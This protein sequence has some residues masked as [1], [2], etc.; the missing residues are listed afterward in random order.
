M[1]GTTLN[2]GS[3]AG[4]SK[5]LSPAFFLGLSLLAH[6]TFFPQEWLLLGAG[7]AFLLSWQSWKSSR[8]NGLRV[9]EENGI[10]SITDVLLFTLVG[11]SLLGLWH[12]VKSSEGWMDAVR[13]GTLWMIYHQARKIPN[14]LEQEKMLSWIER[15]GVLLAVLAW[16]KLFNSWFQGQGFFSAGTERL[17]S[18]FGY[19]NALGVYLAA[20]LLLRPRSKITQALLLLTLLNTGSRAAVFCF[21][22]VWGVQV[23]IRRR[24]AGGAFSSLRKGVLGAVIIISCLCLTWVLNPG[25]FQRL[26]NWGIEN[27]LGERILYLLDG[28][29]LSWSNRGLPR[30]GGWFAFPLVQT[31]P[32]WTSDPH[33]IWI[34]VLLNQGIFGVSALLFWMILILKKIRGGYKHR[35]KDISLLSQ[36]DGDKRLEIFSALF[37]LGWHAMID[38][39]FLFGS[40]GI[41]FW[42]LW[43]MFLPKQLKKDFHLSKLKNILAGLCFLVLALILLRAWVYPQ[44]LDPQKSIEQEMVK[45]EGD[46]QQSLEILKKSLDQDQTQEKVRQE[47]ANLE[48]ELYGA[49][50]LKAAEQVLAWEKFDIHTYEWLQG[51]AIEEA[52]KCRGTDPKD[53]LILYRWSASLPSRLEAASLRPSE[54]MKLLKGTAEEGQLNLPDP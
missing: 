18:L 42:I 6:G 34:R 53:A 20:V 17:S 47:I 28:L 52:E 50:G 31:I 12:P 16:L 51:R 5:V 4:D 15:F 54:L 29:K 24:R 21:L 48:L 9:S 41:L 33:S 23:L 32:Y 1:I 37:F 27:S 25:T 3:K 46:K 7:L 44:W 14:G 22:M 30:A 10:L 43:G 40:L 45:A 35:P 19:P 38:A 39:D 26:L 36:E 8:I 13:W 11:L 2:R 49:G